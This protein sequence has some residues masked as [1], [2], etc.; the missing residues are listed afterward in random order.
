MVTQGE[1]PRFSKIL[2][3]TLEHVKVG[4]EISR[5]DWPF[6]EKE[7]EIAAERVTFHTLDGS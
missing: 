5:V 2:R 3:H 6:D 4:T 7:A 1:I